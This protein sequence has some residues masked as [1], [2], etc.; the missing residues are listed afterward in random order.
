MKVNIQIVTT[1]LWLTFSTGA[2][3]AVIFA[4][5]QRTAA[6]LQGTGRRPGEHSTNGLQF[7]PEVVK[8]LG[9]AWTSGWSLMTKAT[10]VN[11]RAGHLLTET[12]P[13]VYL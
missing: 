6:G 11:V 12:N 5:G 13:C 4:G 10:A 8:S 2:A 7:P 1:A 3:V 9:A